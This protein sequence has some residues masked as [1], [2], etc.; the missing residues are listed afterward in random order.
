MGREIVPIW[1]EAHARIEE[2][3]DVRRLDEGRHRPGTEGVRRERSDFHRPPFRRA[4]LRGRLNSSVY[5]LTL[6]VTPGPRRG[7][8]TNRT[9]IRPGALGTPVP[10]G[11]ALPEA[12][13]RSRTAPATVGTAPT[14]PP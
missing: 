4:I 11:A 1:A 10:A 9:G 8:L 14:P 5:A 13:R 6:R 3:G 7:I 12:R 2:D